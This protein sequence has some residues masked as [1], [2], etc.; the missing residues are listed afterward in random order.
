MEIKENL[1]VQ[2]NFMDMLKIK[3]FLTRTPMA[4][5]CFY[6]M[7]NEV[8]EK[9]PDAYLVIKFKEGI[10]DNSIEIYV[11]KNE[12]NKDNSFMEIVLEI[13]YKYMNK[14]KFLN[15]KIRLAVDYK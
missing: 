12:Y 1:N 11:R 2:C 4:E 8:L 15:P 14:Y 5:I 10:Y 7:C 6:D 3:E 13:T 9:I